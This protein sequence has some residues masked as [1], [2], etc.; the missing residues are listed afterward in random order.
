MKWAMSGLRT[1]TWM[2]F[3]AG[4]VD[5]AVRDATDAGRRCRYR[6]GIVRIQ[7]RSTR[8]SVSSAPAG[9]DHGDLFYDAG[10]A[11]GVGVDSEVGPGKPGPARAAP[12]P[13]SGLLRGRP[14]LR[15]LG[16]SNKPG[17]R[18]R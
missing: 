3:S 17:P 13:L 4:S 14:P 15:A 12:G 9:P 1:K 11:A 16:G 6:R 5:H 8:P 18:A 10:R 2:S 7:A